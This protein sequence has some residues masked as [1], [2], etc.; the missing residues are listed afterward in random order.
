MRQQLPA[1]V[2]AEEEYDG[3]EFTWGSTGLKLTAF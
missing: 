2:R 3:F 1:A